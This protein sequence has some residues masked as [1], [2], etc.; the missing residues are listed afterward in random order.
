M[1]NSN[2]WALLG[3]AGLTTRLTFLSARLMETGII[4]SCSQLKLYKISNIPTEAE[5]KIPH[6]LQL[7]ESAGG[8]LVGA[9]PVAPARPSHWHQAPGRREVLSNIVLVIF[10]CTASLYAKVSIGDLSWWSTD[11][12]DILWLNII[13]DLRDD[14]SGLHF[15]GQKLKRL[16]CQV[17]SFIV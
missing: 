17:T 3:T 7:W 4:A 5:L 10:I 12:V 14:K 13:S 1:M 11:V 8:G 16:Y 6:I 9:L 2:C 15:F